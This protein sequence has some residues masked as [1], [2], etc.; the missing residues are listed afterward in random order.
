MLIQTYP[1]PDYAAVMYTD[2]NIGMV[3]D[4]LEASGAKEETVVAIMGVSNLSR[5]LSAPSQP[6][7]RLSMDAG[8]WLQSGRAEPVVQ[9]DCECWTIV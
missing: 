8:P 2:H 7:H 6:A 1:P 4:T 5:R 9:D 3:L